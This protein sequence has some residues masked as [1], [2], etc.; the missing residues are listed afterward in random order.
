VQAWYN[1][2]KDFNKNNVSPFQWV[3]A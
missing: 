3:F 2:V 1:E